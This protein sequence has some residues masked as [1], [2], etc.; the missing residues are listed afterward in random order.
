MSQFHHDLLA[1]AKAV[2]RDDT[3]PAELLRDTGLFLNHIMAHG[4]LDEVCIAEDYYTI[5]QFQA[6]YD[7]APPC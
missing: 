4:D 1:A 6:A 2:I 7:N 3:E 5:E